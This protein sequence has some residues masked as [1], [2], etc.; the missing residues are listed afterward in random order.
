MNRKQA[1]D[2]AKYLN[3]LPNKCFRNAVPVRVDIAF[4]KTA[5][6]FYGARAQHVRRYGPN[7]KAVTEG[8]ALAGDEYETTRYYLLYSWLGGKAADQEPGLPAKVGA[9]RD[10]DMKY[11]YRFPGDD[12]DW[13]IGTYEAPN[14]GTVG[15]FALHRWDHEKPWMGRI[16]D[17]DD[18]PRD[19]AH[20]TVEVLPEAD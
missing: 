15:W 17:S 12:G 10:R 7:E 4:G 6:S 1:R 8:G 3:E 19:R 20:A 16:D 9:L 18:E 11:V 5:V 14:P 13:Y 2:H